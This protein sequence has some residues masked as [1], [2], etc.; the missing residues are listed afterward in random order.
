MQWLS[1]LLVLCSSF[2]F[3][4]QVNHRT[5][6]PID[7]NGPDSI[8]TIGAISIQGNK[9]THEKII[10][11]EIEFTEG[12]KLSQSQLDS[13]ITESRQN[14]INRSLFNFVT[15]KKMEV[16][17]NIDIDVNV[18]ERWYIWPIP[19]INFADRNLNA[20]WESKDFGRLNYGVDLR[21]DNFRG[22]MEKLN[23]IVQGGFDQMVAA[24]W[25]IP[26]LTKKQFL[27]IAIG[28]GY[29]RNHEV[30]VATEDNKP[31]YYES[32]DGYAQQAA[33]G[34]IDFT[35]RPKF[36]FLHTLTLGFDHIQFQDT[37]LDIN[38]DFT[39]GDTRYDFFTI[40]YLYKLDF[41]DYKPYPLIGYYFDFGIEKQGFGIVD[42]DVNNWTA[43]FV[44][45]HYLQLYKRWYFAYSLA[46]RF[47]DQEYLPYFLTPGI[48][49]QG[50]EIRGYELYI[51]NGQ[52][53][54]VF[55]SNFKFEIIPQTTRRI[56]WIKT[57][58][59]GKVFY[60]LYANLFFDAAYA[61]DHQN[62]RLNPLGN[63]LLW[64]T[65]VGIDFITYY[66]LVIRFEYTIN[67]QGDHGFYL[68]LVAPI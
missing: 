49:Y 57:E 29:Q 60:G 64:G 22:R 47:T 7:L 11:R 33:F 14:L 19:I 35:L 55:K 44:F 39:Y 53:F 62:Y 50:M 3:A 56:K 10:Y 20:W 52:N 43:T 24:K 51:I 63:Q 2:A 23:I 67:K 54:G 58:K 38:P 16:D 4:Q 15:F 36:N 9:I 37:L 31:V 26:Y 65:G 6:R 61:S 18:V 34:T 46:A 5:T 27:G 1:L 59:F 28:G 40:S 21:V 8:V 66:D 42:N 32:V 17:G 41:R 25:T 45:D 12:D 48:G 30:I 13:L 68:N